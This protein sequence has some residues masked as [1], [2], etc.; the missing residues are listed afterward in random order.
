MRIARS[1]RV[2]RIAVCSLAGSVAAAVA[3]G[4][5]AVTQAKSVSSQ[6]L[7]VDTSFVLQTLDPEASHDPTSLMAD[8]AM[9][10]TLLTQG[11]KGVTTSLA[12]KWTES[13]NAKKFEFTLRKGVKFADGTPLT[14]AD[15]VFSIDRL[16]NLKTPISSAVTGWKVKAKGPRGVV[17]TTSVPNPAVPEVLTMPTLGVLNSKLVEQ[18]GGSD[19]KDASK[20]DKAA[21]FFN[22]AS[23]GSG[24][25][26]LSSY[27]P[28]SQVTLKANPNYWGPKPTFKTV[29]IRNMTAPTQLLNVQ[30]GANEVATDLSNAQATTLQSN[31]NLQVHITPSPFTFFLALNTD[32]SVSAV[33]ANP[34]IVQA[35]HDALDYRSMLRSAGPGSIRAAGVIP[36]GIA[37]WLPPKDAAP[38]NIQ[39]AKQEVAASGISDPSITLSY[40]S[41]L[42]V[43]GVEFSTVSQIVQADLA[44]VGITV[45]IQGLPVNTF[46]TQYEA[47]K[48]AMNQVYW[49]INYPDP[50]NADSFAPGGAYST[51]L[52]WNAGANPA[53]TKVVNKASRTINA[54]AKAKLWQ[55]FQN[56][57]NKS[58]P[59]IP[60]FQPAEAVVASANLT[61]VALNS[62]WTMDVAAIRSR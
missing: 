11:S 58:G 22:T 46:L 44:K 28:N 13:K 62:V 8:K 54:S 52:N 48:L 23:A 34:H 27:T 39:K 20:T 41:G 32:P 53:I 19:A 18:H 6:P 43:A 30:R 55:K 57:L 26:E 56:M 33:A 37:G 2:R 25:Y 31:K 49:F 60:E 40:P 51:R 14:S 4:G 12:T 47:G 38:T 7:V 9:Y 16:I 17:I 36:Q 61:H 50:S 21:S 35:I 10:D 3:F 42:T 29:V 5:S 59:Y 24:P 15:V 45:Q 1:S